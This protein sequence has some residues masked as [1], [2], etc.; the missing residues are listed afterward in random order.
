MT[1][2][3][4]WT[5]HLTLCLLVCEVEASWNQEGIPCQTCPV[6]PAGQ[7]IDASHEMGS[8]SL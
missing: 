3:T 2:T 5:Q 1:T 6:P 7:L 8:D 4:N